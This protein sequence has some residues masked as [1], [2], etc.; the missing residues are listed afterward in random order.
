[1]RSV[2]LELEYRKLQSKGYEPRLVRPLHIASLENQWYLFAED[3]ARKQ[4]RTFALPRMR[5]VR[6][7]NKAFRRPAN[8]SIAKVL[9]GSFGVFEGGKK[10]R[11][12]LAFDAFA[13]RL[14]S[15]RTWHESQ[16]FRQVK[17]GSATLAMELGSLEE[18]QRWVL[19]WG[20]HVQVL[21]PPQLRDGVKEQATAVARMYD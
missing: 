15:E 14:V 18:I 5:H 12:R 7:T 13:A 10:H 9:S 21:S 6:L 20:S 16:K 11:I 1:M 4:L 19:S 2:E 8:F 17:D 3:L